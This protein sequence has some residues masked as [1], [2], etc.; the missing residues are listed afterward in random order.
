MEG[1]LR[2]I[3]IL[4]FGLGVRREG[5]GRWGLFVYVCGGG[6]RRVCVRVSCV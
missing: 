6:C 3:W 4:R 2:I 1:R 5:V